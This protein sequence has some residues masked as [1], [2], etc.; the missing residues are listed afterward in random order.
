M[1]PASTDILIRGGRVVDPS[2]ELDREA[3]VLIRE[4]RVAEVGRGLAAGAARVVEAGGKIICPGL[5]DVHVHLR[6]P[7]EEH[8]ETIRTG[9]RAA[10]AGGLATVCGM[11][12]TQPRLYSEDILRDLERRTECDAAC[13]VVPIAWAGA[14]LYGGW[15][16]LARVLKGA[17]GGRASDDGDPIQDREQLRQVLQACAEADALFIAHCEC[18]RLAPE[19]WVMNAGE[20]AEELGVG[21]LPA[22]AEVEAAE[23]LVEVA[24]GVGARVHVAHVSAKETA[25]V[26]RTAQRRGVKVTAEA[27]PHHFTL[28][29]EAVREHGANA[30]MSPPLRGPEDVEAIKEALADGTIEVIATDHAPHAPAEKAQ[31]LLAAPFGVVGLETC[32]GLVFDELVHGGVLNLSEAIAKM[33][34]N[35][36]RALGLPGGTLAIGAPGDVTVID[37]DAEWTVDPDSFES[38]GRN[39]PFA[40]RKLRGKPFATVV[41]GRLRMRDGQILD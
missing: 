19:G 2:Q 16:E 33:T 17:H 11:P 5:M 9:T 15:E 34:V 3:D 27:C 37:P 41:G 18:K 23:Q 31:G 25:E 12:N 8:K 36:A 13:N 28:T 35:P 1:P 4:G 22:A 30:K 40:G 24:Q 6:E 14:T 39:T 38:K 7:G 20:T 32:V 26:I 10:V 21:G 29:E